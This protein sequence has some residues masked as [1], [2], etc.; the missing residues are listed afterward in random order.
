MLGTRAVWVGRWSFFWNINFADEDPLI[1]EDLSISTLSPSN[2]F[3]FFLKQFLF[4]EHYEMS[5]GE[6]LIFK[7]LWS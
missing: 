2:L 7:N 6:I 3:R 5:D 4:L 1:T